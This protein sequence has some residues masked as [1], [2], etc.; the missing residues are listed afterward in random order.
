LPLLVML[1]GCTQS[2]SDFASGTGMNEVADQLGF[3]VLYPEQSVA[4]NIARCWN[5]HRPVNQARGSGEPASIAALTRHVLALCK[6]NEARV[7]IAGISAGGAAAAMTAAL[8]PDLYVAV[9]VHSGLSCGTIT[10]LAQ[11]RMAMRKGTAS[12][13][14]VP[15][16]RAAPPPPTIVFHGDHDT[17]VHPSNADGF[18]H[19]L[20]QSNG[21][22]VQETL[23]GRSDRGRHFTRTTY[24]GCTGDVLLE[25][26]MVHGVGHAWSGGKAIGS[27]TDLD[28]PDASRE[29]ARFFLAR[30]RKC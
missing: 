20:R 5:W 2:A 16:G 14:V 25:T 1:H 30:R 27:H 18:A 19:R 29:M 12:P 8:Y 26:W 4:A 22:L 10:T 6:G 11:A 28:G 17:T 23:A 9:G 15:S 13:P 21:H 7:Y 3:L 24:R